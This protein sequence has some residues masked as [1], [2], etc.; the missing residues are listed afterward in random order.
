[1]N[2]DG[3]QIKPGDNVYDVAYG[4][5]QVTQVKENEQRFVV[6]FGSR[7]FTYQLNGCNGQFPAKTLFWR[8]PISGFVPMKDDA[9]W[10]KFVELRAVMAKVMGRN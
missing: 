2:F 10:A 5:G 3:A 7:Q 4:T 1:M 6:V 8:D 9:T